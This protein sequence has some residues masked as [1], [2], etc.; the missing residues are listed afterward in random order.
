MG[1]GYTKVAMVYVR[2]RGGHSRRQ[3]AKGVRWARVPW[4]DVPKRDPDTT[5]EDVLDEHC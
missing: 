2:T 1:L 5:A 3:R 4:F